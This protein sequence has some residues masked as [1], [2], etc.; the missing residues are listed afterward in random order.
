MSDTE[1][2][3]TAKMVLDDSGY[4]STLK[5]IN[6]ELRNNKSELRAASTGLDAFGKSTANLNRVQE[7]L[8]KQLDLQNKKLS[9]YKDS[10]DKATTQLDSN[11]NKR[12]ELNSSLE[13]EKAKLE[14]LKKTYGSNSEAVKN[15][16]K[17]VQDL[18]EELDKTDTSIE[19]NAKRIQ[20]YENNLNKAEAEINKTTS[21]L[22]KMNKE[23]KEQSGIK[24]VSENLNAA[25]TGMKKFGKGAKEV[26]SNLT[27]HVTLPLAAV[28]GMAAKVGMDFE[29]QMSR[30]QAISGATGDEFKTLEDQA[31]KL[32][33]ST[34]FSA[35]EC[36]EGMENLASA[37]FNVNEIT[38]AMPGL[39]DLAASSGEDLANSSEIAAGTL[40][41]FGLE[42]KQAGHV[43]DVL[44][45]NAADTNA[46]V[47]DT[48]E[49]MK[50]IAPVAHAMG[51]SL[52]EVTASVGVM[53]DA[54]IKG[55]QAGTTLRSALTRLAKPSDEAAAKMKAIGFNAF[56]S[57]GKLKNLSTITGELSNA[58]KNMTDKQKEA[59]IAQ[60]FGQ[61]AMSGM[62]VLM[63]NGPDKINNL[64]NSL[65][66]C[67]GAA[68]EM[69]TTMQDNTKASIE[70]AFGALETAGIKALKAAAPMIE[71]VAE[72][73]GDLADKFSSLS[74]ETQNFIVT[75]GL[76]AMVAG[77]A[78]SG[79]G[80]LA[81]G[82]G[83]ITGLAG[84]AASALG[85]VST[86]ST[87]ATT[88]TAAVGTAAAE[89]GV[90]TASAGAATAG[91]GVTLGGIALP[92]A[93][94]AAAVAA[95]GY[96]GYKTYKYLNESA[97][98]AVDLFADKTEYSTQRVSGAYG[99]MVQTVKTGT[100]KISESTKKGVQAYLDMDKKASDSLMNLRMNSD[101]FTK[102]AKNKVLK[103]FTDMSKKSSNLSKEQRE[104]MTVDFKKLVSDTGVLTK[105]NKDEII[106]QYTAMVNGT[107]GLSKKQKDQMI[108]DFNE[109]LKQS[110]GIT[111][112]QSAELQ[113]QYKDMSTK[114]KKGM[115]TKREEELKSQKDFFN[116]S[117]V[118][119][120]KEEADILK[121]TTDSW[122]KKKENVDK[123]QGEI[124]K[125]I[126]K[127][128][129]DHR[130]INNDEAKT[131]DEIQK[132]M[133]EQAVKTLSA[134]ETEAKVI[135]ERMKGNEENITAEMAADKI[136]KL[137]ESRDKAVNTA[138]DECDKRL[139][140]II[141]MRDESK[142]ISAEQA[143]KLI[144]DAKK[145]KDETVKAAEETRNQAVDKIKAMN[146]DIGE[147]V[148]TTT[149]EV[150]TKWDKFKNW[151]SSWWPEPKKLTVTEERNL[152][153]PMAGRNWTG[154][155]Y[156]RGGLTY[157]HER[158]EELYD[159]PEGTRIY[160][161]E[162][163]EQMVLATAKETA[164][165]IAK[166]MLNSDNQS[167]NI[168]IPISIA[169][170]KVDE[171][172]V[173]RVSNKFALAGRRKL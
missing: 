59:T 1:K 166:S 137:N 99:G 2:R 43:A 105:K 25:S 35:N 115:D 62:L 158:G 89:A 8:Q 19:N 75:A 13:K 86:A 69:A 168:I 64:T 37:G 121:K 128:A 49:A 133:K 112:K 118:L 113:K 136:K 95:V 171:I 27:S 119:T 74:P 65:K 6:S 130:Q 48:G 109:T 116:K 134:N 144:A 20:N 129:K 160:N 33:Q 145:Q 132:K 156:F 87:A 157:L 50:Y 153:N 29:A 77:P 163:S 164:E 170:K 161:H 7:S 71:K 152:N 83:A 141:R 47:G 124:N 146:S 85:L 45:K 52:E 88:A 11:I 23:L 24:S 106:K 46:A 114:I 73:V 91:L 55:S 76:M 167:G 172:I 53:A 131:I 70:Q 68:N 159:L 30:V 3:I 4:S 151:W 66:H 90:A 84:K 125:I 135:L 22:N 110:V 142:V 39:L 97:T 150:L 42:A 54:N 17:K 103:N 28:G 98:P 138:N 56:D 140:E 126:E 127:A 104:K 80:N 15:A 173:P 26:G 102:D 108:K 10:I 34:A 162:M 36:A 9:V 139:A 63:Q 79:I 40:R 38:E 122:N 123:L 18:K 78:I 155:S 96:A 72:V 100:I 149:G 14:S 57:K 111:K 147:D 41:G 148:N 81:N 31:L 21:E 32:G 60:I 93:A 169:G 12:N 51:L 5:G 61:E 154:N 143:E 92:L 120:T 165:N 82:I 117:N 67:D 94:G 44:A 107:K 58:T 101:K 16:E